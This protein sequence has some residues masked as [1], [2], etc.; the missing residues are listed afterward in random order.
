M[1]S[2]LITKDFDA[3]IEQIFELLSKHDTYNVAF[4]PMQVERIKDALDVNRPDGVGSIR[5]LG[6]GK[7]KPLQEQITLLLPNER[8]EYKII[9]NPLVKHHIGII[10]FEVIEERITRVNYTIEL[11]MRLPFVSKL[12]LAQLKS[13]IK[14]GFSKLAKTV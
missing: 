12:I 3:P 11:Q 2:I 8:I 14:L 4:A 6:L 13:G 10:T 5:K 7:V 9:K 1:D